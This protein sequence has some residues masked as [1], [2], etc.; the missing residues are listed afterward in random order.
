LGNGWALDSYSRTE[1][2]N[3]DPNAPADN[4]YGAGN[5]CRKYT[6]ARSPSQ[7]F[8]FTEAT[9]SHGIND[10]NYYVR[11]SAGSPGAFTWFVPPAQYHVNLGNFAFA[12]G[13]SDHHRWYDGHL[14]TTG[15]NAARGQPISGIFSGPV[16]GLDYDFFRTGYLFP[17]WQ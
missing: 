17:G 1:N 3:G 8:V 16:A 6:D 14:V 12:D 13:H 10:D 5:T 9:D 11:W 4:Y 7:N 2:F 15:Q